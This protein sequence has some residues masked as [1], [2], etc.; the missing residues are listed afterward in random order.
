MPPASFEKW[1][2][3]AVVDGCRAEARRPREEEE[4]VCFE[5][6]VRALGDEGA[7]AWAA[8]QHQYDRLVRR[9]LRRAATA[10]LSAA[11]VDDLLQETWLRFWN[12]LR[13]RGQPL[14]RHFPHVGGVLRYLNQCAVSAVLDQG[15]TARRLAE[16]DA[17]LSAGPDDFIADRPRAVIDQVADRMQKERRLAKMAA[18]IKNRVDDP[19]ERLILEESFVNGL[20]P[21]E[22]ALKHPDHFADV[23]EVRKVK[24]RLVKRAR[25]ALYEGNEK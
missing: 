22:I 7:A 25:R 6:F 8:V 11:E 10:P 21:L 9:W 14:R 19:Q 20:E 17:R 5:L 23:K 12:T 16:L 4:G 2:L 24:E 1:N 18:W 13:Q 15:R 3:D